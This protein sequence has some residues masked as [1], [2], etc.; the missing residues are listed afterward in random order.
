VAR[1][2]A[3]FSEYKKNPK[4]T[5]IR[6]YYEMFEEVFKHPENTDLIDKQLSNFIPF[7]SLNIPEKGGNK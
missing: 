6:L 1:F 5:R 7:K 4:L 2:L 3:V